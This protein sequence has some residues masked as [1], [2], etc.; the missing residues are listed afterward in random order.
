MKKLNTQ[1]FST[2]A[3]E[4]MFNVRGGDGNDGKNTTASNTTAKTLTKDII[5]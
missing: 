4:E 2:L 5:L 3:T 1:N